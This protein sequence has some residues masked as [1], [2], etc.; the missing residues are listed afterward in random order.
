VGREL[1]Y[2]DHWSLR[3]DL[4]ILGRTLGAVLRRDRP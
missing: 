4:A 2:L 1:Q 3:L